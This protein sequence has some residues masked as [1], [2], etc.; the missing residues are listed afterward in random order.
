MRGHP[1]ASPRSLRIH[2]ISRAAIPICLLGRFAPRPA[3]RAAWRIVMP[4]FSPCIPLLAP[5]CVAS[6]LRFAHRAVWRAARP[7]LPLRLPVSVSC[8]L[9]HR[10]P[11]V[12]ALASYRSPP[13]SSP[14][15][16]PSPRRSCRKTGRR[17]L[18]YRH[19]GRLLAW[20]AV[21]FLSKN[22][23]R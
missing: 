19:A 11:I 4:P 21:L 17:H 9:P 23:P 2:Y 22:S 16:A 20:R 12:M 5:L 3:P 13:R 18:A 15:F 14:R 1:L 6:F 10:F 7:R 8:L